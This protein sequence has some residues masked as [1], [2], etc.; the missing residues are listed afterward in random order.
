M[1]IHM[2]LHDLV[3][4]L[5]KRIDELRA[6]GTKVQIQPNGFMRLA[7]EGQKNADNG[8]FLH[9]WIPELP[10]QRFLHTHVF[11]LVSRVLKGSIKD[12][13]YQM[14]P[15][16]DGPYKLVKSRCTQEDCTI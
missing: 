2:E 16:D 11:H 5:L 10:C 7:L 6:A 4:A 12:T 13:M 1:N 9:T 3:R 8:L 15:D 14:I